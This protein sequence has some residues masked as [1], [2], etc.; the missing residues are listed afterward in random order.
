MAAKATEATV[1]ATEVIKP[2]RRRAAG[3]AA[4]AEA[5]AIVKAP[6]KALKAADPKPVAPKAAAKPVAA[7]AAAAPKAAAKPK[8][9]KVAKPKGEPK[10]PRYTEEEDAELLALANGDGKNE[11]LGRMKA[12]RKFV[13]LHPGR[14]VY[15]TDCRYQRLKKQLGL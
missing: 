3:P 15:G 13:E 12:V 7:K 8:V 10:G 6:A 1:E 11:G 4:V 9:E 14:T 5:K 2:A